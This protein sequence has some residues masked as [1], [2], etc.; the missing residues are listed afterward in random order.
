MSLNQNL[1]QRVF[2]YFFVK[3][4]RIE[5]ARTLLSRVMPELCK[6]ITLVVLKG[7]NLLAIRKYWRFSECDMAPCLDWSNGQFPIKSL[8]TSVPTVSC[9]S[10][11]VSW[12]CEFLRLPT[13]QLSKQQGE[14]AVSIPVF[15]GSLL[16]NKLHL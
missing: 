10:S 1:I 15:S 4:C 3:L 12:V 8:R 2:T 9:A 6:L 16:L 5:D 11:G 14:V 7:Q 13:A